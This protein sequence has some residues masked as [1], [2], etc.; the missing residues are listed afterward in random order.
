MSGILYPEQTEY[1]EKLRNENREILFEL[2]KYASEN[3][4]PIINWNAAEFLEQL[5]SIHKPERVLE[6][7][8]AIGYSAIR[9]AYRMEKGTLI[10]TIELSKHNI[11]KA[12]NNIAKA[13]F[14]DVIKV[15]SGS[16]SVIME[17]LKP[18][19]DFIFLDVDKKD[20]AQLFEKALTVLKVGGVLFVDNLL[21]QGFA[22]S[23]EVP[24]KYKISSEQIRNFNLLFKSEE[25]LQST[26]LPV[27]DGI[28]IG[29]KIK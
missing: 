10:D 19:Y 12:E 9:M 16:A 13:G 15:H 21:W 24:E 18:G 25:T 7:G 2:E 11:P 6:L 5:I 14:S 8:T 22:A 23:S 17:K 27:G 4:V 26:I 3:S 28:G 1:L 20:Y 29:I